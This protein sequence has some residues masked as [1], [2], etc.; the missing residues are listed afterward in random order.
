MVEAELTREK[1]RRGV[2]EAVP[3]RLGRD[4]VGRDSVGI[5][6]VLT[7][8]DSVDRGSV[9]AHRLNRGARA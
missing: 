7:W 3:Y 4:L 1:L 2:V 9:R 5:Y 8:G 6:L